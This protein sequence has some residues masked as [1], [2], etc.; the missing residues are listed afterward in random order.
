MKE[1]SRTR[2]EAL[3]LRDNDNKKTITYTG[4]SDIIILYSERTAIAH[5]LTSDYSLPYIVYSALFMLFGLFAL[6]FNPHILMKLMLVFN[7]KIEKAFLLIA[8]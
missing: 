2:H 8:Y 4:S 5:C 7:F 3:D 6:L 1:F